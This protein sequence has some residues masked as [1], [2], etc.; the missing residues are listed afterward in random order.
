MDI[1]EIKIK[2]AAKKHSMVTLYRTDDGGVAAENGAFA[3]IAKFSRTDS[4]E[5]AF[6][7]A[8]VLAEEIWGKATRGTGP[9]ATNSMVHDLI[10]LIDRVMAA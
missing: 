5:E 7:K 9:A 8:R 2:T 1:R 10:G 3:C 6:A 4:P